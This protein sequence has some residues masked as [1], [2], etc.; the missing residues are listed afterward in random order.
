MHARQRRPPLL[1]VS[2]NIGDGCGS[3]SNRTD[4]QS[5]ERRVSPKLAP[6]YSDPFQILRRIG[7]VAYELRMPTTLKIHPTFHASLLRSYKR[8]SPSHLSN[9]S[10]ISRLLKITLTQTSSHLLQ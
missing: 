3:A 8:P 2:F 5:V 6:R 1:D 10:A 4:R 7:T 9:S